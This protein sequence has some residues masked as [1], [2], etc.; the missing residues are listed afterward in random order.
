MVWV[1]LHTWRLSGLI[2]LLFSSSNSTSADDLHPYSRGRRH[3]PRRSYDEVFEWFENRSLSPFEQFT[4]PRPINVVSPASVTV[5]GF[6]ATNGNA[7]PR[8][9]TNAK[10]ITVANPL[11]SIS[12]YEPKSGCGNV[13]TV[14]E[15]AR[16]YH[17]I[18]AV[19]AGFFNK[20]QVDPTAEDNACFGNLVSNGNIINDNGT[21][22]VNF[23]IRA[24]GALFTGYVDSSDITIES[25]NQFVQLIAGVIWLVRN[26]T[27][28]VQESIDIESEFPEHSGTLEYFATL[29]SARVA[30]GHDKNGNVLIAQFD[31]KSGDHGI[32][33]NVM[34]AL[35]IDLGFVNAINLD[36]GGSAT[37]VINGT[38]VSELTESNCP[39]GRQL[40]ENSGLETR[41][42]R[43]VSSIICAHAPICYKCRKN[44][45]CI[46]KACFTAP[47]TT[48]PSH[49]P[50]T[51]TPT[52]S[53][54]STSPT[55]SPS[56]SPSMSPTQSP[57]NSPT[58]LPTSSP[59][60]FKMSLETR[61][62]VAFAVCLV[63][64]ILAVTL[65]VLSLRRQHSSG[66]SGSFS[67][68]I[69]CDDESS[70]HT[71]LEYVNPEFD[72]LYSDGEDDND[73]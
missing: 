47:P 34:A 60:V 40:P 10:I 69:N 36:G 20:D 46:T 13:S 22:N 55:H 21:A 50:T 38:V 42:E 72:G 48:S 18:A 62:K 64:A 61:W 45:K 56:F 15:S 63:S 52:T 66:A 2:L 7:W 3:G 73:E 32:D 24:N 23:G 31:G 53:S 58:M 51:S 26:G 67:K 12:V 54:P 1:C 8:E 30:V 27:S 57:T 71:L 70:R 11:N 33:L 19:N 41:C 39:D 4:P 44:H 49:S 5:E 68:L 37:C 25:K 65:L 43:P 29:T 6:M 16:H 14:G 28:F 35:L 17:C 9:K 59:T